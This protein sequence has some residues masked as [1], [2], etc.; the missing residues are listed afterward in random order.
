MSATAANTAGPIAA[1]P[2]PLTTRVATMASYVGASADPRDASAQQS[3]AGHDSWL[4]AVEVADRA[5]DERKRRG[6]DGRQRHE[7]T[8]LAN[9][10]AK[11][12]AQ[13]HQER[14]DDEHGEWEE[15]AHARRTA[16]MILSFAPDT[17]RFDSVRLNSDGDKASGGMPV[18]CEDVALAAR[19]SI[20]SSGGRS[21]IRRH[22]KLYWA[23]LSGLTAQRQRRY[24]HKNSQER[25]S[26]WHSLPFW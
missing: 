26:V 24:T 21:R 13:V 3:R 1:P 6:R 14:G 8:S 7:L 16:S 5:D 11:I 20:S 17:A 19:S 15:K 18:G 2:T 12:K 25:F 23:A 4:A 22:G 10:D 9:A